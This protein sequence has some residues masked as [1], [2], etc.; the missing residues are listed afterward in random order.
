M[1]ENR[2]DEREFCISPLLNN[3]LDK[4]KFRV[5]AKE[6]CFSPLNNVRVYLVW[7]DYWNQKYN[8][9][10]DSQ[11]NFPMQ[12]IPETVLKELCKKLTG[13][14]IWQKK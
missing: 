10:E 12:S 5:R 13:K 11:S 14:D 4:P 7:I 1:S 8:R 2:N 3:I 6:T 9:W